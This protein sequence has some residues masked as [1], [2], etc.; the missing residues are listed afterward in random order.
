MADVIQ[1]IRPT[2]PIRHGAAVVSVNKFGTI[3]VVEERAR[4]ATSGELSEI[5]D[6]LTTRFD[7]PTYYS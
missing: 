3:E 1:T 4:V 5:E 6:K 7:D 2:Q